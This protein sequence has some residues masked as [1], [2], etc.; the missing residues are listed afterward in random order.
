MKRFKKLDAVENAQ[1]VINIVAKYIGENSETMALVKHRLKSGV[2][3]TVIAKELADML[4]E[5]ID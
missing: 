3:P 1:N 2:C 4:K 5:T